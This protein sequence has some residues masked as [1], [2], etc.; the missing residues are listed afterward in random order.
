[1]ADADHDA[2]NPETAAPA[3]APNEQYEENAMQPLRVF[4]VVPK[5]PEALAPLRDLAFNL[6]FAW[7][8]DIARLFTRMDM[9]L[10]RECDGNP[11]MFL[12]RVPQK[13]LEMMA[14]DEG[15]VARVR[16][17]R[18]QLEE[19]LSSSHCAV[20]FPDTGKGH[21][22]VAYFSLEYGTSPSL[23]IYSGGLGI[24]AGDHL[25]S[26]SDL[27]IPL[28]GVGLAYRNG[29]FRQYLTPDGWQQERYPD[30]DFEQMPI[31]LLRDDNGSELTVTVDLAGQ[32]C[33]ARIWR[34]DIGRIPLYLLDTNYEANPEHVRSLTM[35]LYGGD[36][37]HRVQQEIL[38]G[39]GGLRALR[40]LGI[41]PHV[42]HMNEGHSAFVGLERIRTFMHEDH[43][44]FE[45][46]ME[47]TASSS[48]FTTH[49]PVP[50]GN[51][52]FPADLMERYFAGYAQQLGLAFKVFLALGRENPM[53]D[54][55]HFCMTVLALKL[56]RINNGVS[57]LHGKVSRN[58]WKRVWPQYSVEDIPIGAVTNGVHAPSWVAAELAELFDR[59]V[60]P[61]WREESDSA[62]VW[63]QID[64][65]S[66]A[67]LWRTHER[68]RARLVDFVRQRLRGQLM[69]KGVRRRALEI[70][71]EV[72]D[73]DVLTIGFARR[74]ATYKRANLILQDTER[75][76][77]LLHNK[78]RPIQFII[79]GKA[80]P[81]DNEGK[82]LI[83]DLVSLCR[84]GDCRH[85]LIFIEDYDMEVA[86]RLVQGCDVWLNNPRVPLEACGTSGMKAMVNGVLN[87]S[88]LD[89]W[90][91]EAYRSDNSVGW[92]IGRGETYDDL[93]Y[94]D[95]VES[96]TLYNLLENEVIPLFYE[97]SHGNIPRAWVSK[98]RNAFKECGPAF[99]SHRMVV[100]YARDSYL[101]AY[102]NA[103]MLM[104][105]NFAAA[106]ELADWRMG[107]MTNWNNVRITNVTAEQFDELHVGQGVSVE[108]DVHIG[109]VSP[110]HLRVEIYAGPL[111][112]A[113]Q[114]AKRRTFIMRPMSDP[115]G[116]TIRYKGTFEPFEA[117]RVGFTV[118]ALPSHP[119]LVN[120]HSLGLIRWADD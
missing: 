14:H 60:G 75:L 18:S 19:Y 105:D 26:S 33:H 86:E 56:S 35:R 99:N 110:E 108:A 119:L 10:W 46:A 6:W 118:R 41:N 76:L 63:E 47:M 23:P 98:M 109:N 39:I 70:A 93:E 13:T 51:D 5:L 3:A 68:L 116:E 49:T 44:P 81:K 101:P 29:Y 7:N 52:R 72:L 58:M 92:A 113:R 50:A 69:A 62:K 34:A 28:V 30:Y 90:W 78:E 67:E 88:T 36:L 65:I 42:T 22:A 87:L 117:G 73:P 106:K 94:Q 120:P 89:G 82:K 20:E 114:F 2:D 45:A 38:L 12:N 27:N 84:S 80:H 79:A 37:E 17:V 53:D 61:H 1:M 64:T 21:P 57:K 112:Q 59:Y 83:Q 8:D 11:V 9:R 66:D 103:R 115:M 15:Y 16:E 31:Q 102:L 24:L 32:E 55:E 100:D 74:F 77:K 71:E 40:K 104:N 95:F 91:A 85:N 111:D 97:R 43:L 96:Q 48:I 107:L 4:S 54:A 25:K